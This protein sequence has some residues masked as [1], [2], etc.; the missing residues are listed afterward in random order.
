MASS[1]LS[2]IASIITGIIVTLSYPGIFLLMALESACIPIPSEIIMPFAG[3]LAFSGKF[4]FWLIVIVGVLG[5]LV[6][7]LLAYWVGKEGRGFV[8]KYGKYILISNHDLKR[9]DRWFL[10]YGESTV[11]FSRLLPV[12]RTFISLPAGLAKMDWKKF[13][14][15][16]T[17]GSLPWSIALTYLGFK[18]GERW[19]I[20][21]FYFHK[22]DLLIGIILVG[23]IIWYIKRHIKS[24][25]K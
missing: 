8:E 17:L 7:S 19:E 6:G 25:K 12:I 4:N 11:F 18:L 5:N 21:G 16:T 22:F 2:F 9:A 13:S 15:Y 14:L 10:K 23:G 3:F 1:I 24:Y 20:L